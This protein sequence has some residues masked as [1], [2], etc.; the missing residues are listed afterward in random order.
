V[1]HEAWPSTSEEMETSGIAARIFAR[2]K[3]ALRLERTRAERA[4]AT[5][6]RRASAGNWSAAA[7][8]DDKLDI[9]RLPLPAA[10]ARQRNRRR[11]RHSP[12]SPPPSRKEG[13]M[14]DNRITVEL[15]TDVL[16]VLH[17]HG[18]TRGDDMHAG[19]AA[20]LAGDLARI[21]EG[22]QDYPYVRRPLHRAPIPPPLEPAGQDNR[23]PVILQ[24]GERTT[25]LI[26]LDIAADDMR[27]RAG[28]CTDC[29][30]QSCFACESRL[31]DARAYDQLSDRIL[32]AAEADPAP[33]H[34]QAESASSARQPRLAADKEAGQ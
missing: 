9:P 3:V 26:A 18:F 15:F 30:D 5:L 19:R 6:A 12:A 32:Q 4:T 1:T 22:T 21:Y 33:H 29:P 34:G 23:D 16:D 31:R 28:M 10:G 7:Q 11:P 25:M 20:L 2:D 27:N 8:D 14:R 13:H 24:A 17:R